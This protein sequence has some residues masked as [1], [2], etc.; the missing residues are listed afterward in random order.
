MEMQ[1]DFQ[2]WMEIREYSFFITDLAEN[3]SKSSSYVYLVYKLVQKLLVHIEVQACSIFLCS[4]RL[5]VVTANEISTA[6]DRFV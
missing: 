4:S 1:L 3:G 6:V 5:N 2:N